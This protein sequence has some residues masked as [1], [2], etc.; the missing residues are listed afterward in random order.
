MIHR[1]KMKLFTVAFLICVCYSYATFVQNFSQPTSTTSTNVVWDIA[2]TNYGG[3]ELH[4]GD[5]FLF[6]VPLYYQKGIVRNVILVHRKDEKFDGSI[7]YKTDGTYY[8]SQGAYD[9]IQLVNMENGYKESWIAPKFAEPRSPSE[10][11]EENLHDWVYYVGI[12]ST[13][14]VY[15]Q[16]VSPVS[17]PLAVANIHKVAIEFFPSGTIAFTQIDIYSTGTSFIDLSKGQLE[18]TYGGGPPAGLTYAEMEAEGIYPNAIEIGTYGIKTNVSSEVY[19]DY[20]GQMH[21]KIPAGKKLGG[22]EISIGDTKYDKSKPPQDQINKDGG[23]GQLGWA[24]ITATL[25]ISQEECIT[26]ANVP[27]AGV[28]SGGPQSQNYIV[29][30]NEEIVVYSSSYAWVMGYKIVFM[31]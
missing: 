14:L 10:P 20:Y 30:S 16:N 5:I 22:F 3:L 2:A 29:N 26:S 27:P 19:V 28:L 31:K 13:D 11:E 4:P 24:K 15:L 8:D 1:E 17:E 23:Y 12:F 18:P 7:E 21:I 9:S 25:S 6:D